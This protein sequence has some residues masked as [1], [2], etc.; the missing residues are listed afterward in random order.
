ML[1]DEQTF[2]DLEVFEAQG[3]AP[4][5]FDLLNHARTSGGVEWLRGR[6]RRPLSSVEEIRAVQQSLRFIAANRAGFELLPDQG[7]ISGLQ[8][9][10]H[11]NEMV[12]TTPAGAGA[13]IEALM[14]RFSDRKQVARTVAGVRRTA[15]AITALSRFA[16]QPGMADAPG[17]LG[18]LL[19]EMRALLERP[20]LAALTG[21]V[22]PE[23]VWWRVF[24]LDRQLRREER[25]GIERL[26]R[27]VFEIDALLSMAIAGQEQRFV[28]PEVHD[29]PPA[30]SAD[31]VYHPFLIHPVANPL[32]VGE[33][34]RLLFI[35]GPNMAG[36][37]TYLRAC[38]TAVYLAH[39][40][41]GVPA[42]S[43]RFSPCDALFSAITLADNVRE[44][45][46]FF[47]AE[48]LRVKRIAQAL[49]DGRRVC[50]LLDEPFKG[51]NVKDALDASRAVFTRMA[52]AEGS[53]FLVSSHLIELASV[54]EPLPTVDC[55]RFEAAEEGGT[56]QYDFVLRP[57]VSTQRLGVRVLEEEGVFEL[58][59]RAVEGRGAAHQTS[60]ER[61]AAAS[62]AE[63]NGTGTRVRRSHE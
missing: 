14:V 39:L 50:A 3:S 55:Y 53:I 32:R 15:A 7:T 28:L 48:A 36:K 43:F 63:G 38:G 45:V 1:I 18:P 62:M 23:L 57:G 58:L 11:S 27:I 49:A 35:T 37:T 19:A 24:R 17:E 51:T 56:L 10:I 2:R 52:E 42:R 13:V 4:S 40:G 5:L 54:L 29:G 47:R 59:E 26:M 34:H 46:S 20:A 44:G 33:S 9:F 22:E 60:A 61:A 41:M 6:F 25:P 12:I 16:L 8:R 30:V 21:D 31:G